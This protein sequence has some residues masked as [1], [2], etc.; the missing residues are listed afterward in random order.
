MTKKANPAPPNSK[1]RS[2]SPPGPPKAQPVKP[3]PAKVPKHIPKSSNAEN[4]T[5]H[6]NV[7]KDEKRVV[8][9]VEIGNNL[10]KTLDAAIKAAYQASENI[11]ETL[12]AAGL[13]IKSMVESSVK[14][15]GVTKK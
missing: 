9:Y 12:E 11:G 7:E 10:Q 13:D 3:A 6:Y 4:V 15:V 2:L 14:A 8:V 1:K 5:A